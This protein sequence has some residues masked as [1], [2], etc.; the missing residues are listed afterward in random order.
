MTQTRWHKLCAILTLSLMVLVGCVQQTAPGMPS[1]SPETNKLRVHFIDVGQADAILVQ[2][3]EGE[4]LLIDGGNGADGELVANY[5]KKQGISKLTAVVATHP[6]EDHI[7]GLPD[8]LLALGT[9]TLYMPDATTTTKTFERLLDAAEKRADKVTQAKTGMKFSVGSAEATIL[10]PN[11]GQ[12]FEELNNY[13]VV[14]QLKYGST[15]MLFTGDAEQPVEQI[16]L[17]N[18]VGLRSDLLKVGHHGGSTSSSDAFLKAVAPKLAVISV[19]KDNDYGHPHRETM[20]RL[21]KTS[22]RIL[23]T[24]RDGTI[25]VAS[26]GKSLVVEQPR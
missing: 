26:D 5:L 1:P 19:G 12:R 13:S 4:S 15:T 8:A 6:H 22:A 14:L 16:L 17:K 9:K 7:G 20:Q 23:R 3:P 24:D 10:S 18:A 25:V 2:S 11:A 21:E